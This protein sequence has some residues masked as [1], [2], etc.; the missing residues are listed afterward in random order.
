MAAF[1]LTVKTLELAIQILLYSLIIPKDRGFITLDAILNII[2]IE[3]RF[4]PIKLKTGVL[5]VRN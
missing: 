3:P 4:M 2:K 5:L 1:T